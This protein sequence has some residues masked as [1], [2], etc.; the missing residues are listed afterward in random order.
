MDFMTQTII[1]VMAQLISA[2]FKLCAIAQLGN[3]SYIQLSFS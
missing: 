3:I 1:T 2:Q